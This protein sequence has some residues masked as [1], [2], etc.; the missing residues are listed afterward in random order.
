[1]TAASALA[2][3]SRRV[4]SAR[5]LERRIAGVEVGVAGR[6]VAGGRGVVLGYHRVTRSDLDPFRLAVDPKAF[7]RHVAMLARNF[8]PM[9]LGELVEAARRRAIPSRAVAVTFDDGY[10]DNLLE[11]APLLHDAG[12]PATVFVSTAALGTG[13]TLW[14]HALELSL[15]GPGERPARL[16]LR[17]DG[18]ER[19]WD[20]RTLDDRRRAHDEIQNLLRYAP[21]GTIETVLEQLRAWSPAEAIAPADGPR[22]M[23]VDE[24]RQLAD[25]GMEVGAHGH[26]HLSLLGQRG[27]TVRAELR[28]SREV[29]TEALGRPP[30]GF[31]YPFGDHGLL[32]RIA[33]RRAGFGWAVGVQPAAMTSFSNRLNLPRLVL[34]HEDAD[35]LERR[36]TALLDGSRNGGGP[37]G[38]VRTR[39]FR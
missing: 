28:R 2:D 23:T 3:P 15:L 33:V 14:W 16:T 32:D 13:S 36:V 31:A 11:A 39:R 18:V 6:R 22:V 12:V 30:V 27:T 35:Q 4:R 8:R 34:G 24:L 29:L 19:S 38:K 1:V 20:T 9:A 21:R 5:W 7:A 10:V 37:R 26:H 25:W 17:V